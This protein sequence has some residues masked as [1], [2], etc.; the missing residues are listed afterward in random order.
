MQ[1]FKLDSP[2][3]IGQLNHH[4]EIKEKVLQQIDEQPTFT[5]LSEPF[6]NVNITKSDWETNRWD[7]SRPWANTLMEHLGPHLGEVT[8]LLGYVEYK[9]H[10]L[11]FQQYEKSSG[12]GWHVHGS[13]WTN[14]YFLEFPEDCPKTEFIDPLTQITVQQFNVKEGDVLTFPSYVIHRAPVNNSD[15]RKTIVSWNMDTELKPG[16]YK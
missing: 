8:K 10:E 4:Q 2:F 7:H 14:V 6:D 3:I 13:N 5:R 15:N 11:W 12:H 16:L 1:K 9:I